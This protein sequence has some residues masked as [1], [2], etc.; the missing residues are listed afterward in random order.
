[1]YRRLPRLCKQCILGNSRHFAP[2]QSRRRPIRCCRTSAQL[3]C[4]GR[5]H[6]HRARRR[7]RRRRSRGWRAHLPKVAQR[8]ALRLTPDSRLAWDSQWLVSPWPGRVAA[9]VAQLPLSA[10]SRCP[11]AN[12]I[13]GPRCALAIFALFVPTRVKAWAQA[14]VPAAASYAIF[15]RSALW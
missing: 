13:V 10:H 2:S 1:M 12:A 7:S 11:H 8:R 3:W 6:R 14:F 9:S 4:R 5:G 15:E